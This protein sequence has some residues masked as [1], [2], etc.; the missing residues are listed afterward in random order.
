MSPAPRV[1][2]C[3]Q[4]FCWLPGAAVSVPRFSLPGVRVLGQAGL[5]VS[6]ST[7]SL[8]ADTT[9]TGLWPYCRLWELENSWFVPG[10][11][12]IPAGQWLRVRGS[13]GCSPGPCLAFPLGCV[14][15]PLGAGQSTPA[16]GTKIIPPREGNPPALRQG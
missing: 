16:P 4:E 1:K 11:S 3:L 12:F 15:C 13:A 9:S 8:A 2:S 6:P 7:L 14:W 5:W 10:E